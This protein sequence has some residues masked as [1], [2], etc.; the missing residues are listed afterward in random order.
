VSKNVEHGYTYKVEWSEEDGEYVGTVEES[1]GL[2]WVD[3]SPTKTLAGIRRITEECVEDA[4]QQ[5][6]QTTRLIA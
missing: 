2:S 1:P 6:N 5:K 3:D 4:S